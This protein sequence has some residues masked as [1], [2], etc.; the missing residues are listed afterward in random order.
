M[1]QHGPSRY[2]LK[3][4]ITHSQ[5]ENLGSCEGQICISHV[6][7]ITMYLWWK[8]QFVVQIIS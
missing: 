7:A 1:N 6:T 5:K 2:H 8:T 4:K 3:N